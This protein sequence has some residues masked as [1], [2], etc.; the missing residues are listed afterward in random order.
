MHKIKPLQYLCIVTITLFFGKFYSVSY[1]QQQ[2]VDPNQGGYWIAYIGD[3]KLN[4]HIGIH[5]EVQ[6][7]NYF[8][9]ETVESLIL[10]TGLNIYIKPYAM[11]TA[12]Y[13]YVY[14]NPSEDYINASRISEHRTWQQL[15]LRQKSHA[16]FMEHRYRLEQRFL[17]NQT[18]GTSRI[19]HRIRYRFQTLLPLY[20]LSPHLRH[21]FVA[22]NDEI[23][24]NFRNTP[25]M[26]FDRN[27]FFAGIGFQVS[28]KLNFQ[29]GY[30]NQFAQ[31]T[32]KTTAHIDHILQFGISY[33][34]DDLMPTFL[35]KTDK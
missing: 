16:I 1:G 30:M 23:M 26:L 7:R 31:V 15:I 22:L 19:D 24:I 20:S 29:L 18:T 14:S 21:F 32:G 10:R 4:K 35:K 13:A 9:K 33:N 17:E 6:L 28:P 2:S 5:S 34:M 27:R 8:I 25:S 11:A 12:G 3:N